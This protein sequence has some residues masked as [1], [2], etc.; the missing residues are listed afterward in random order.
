MELEL[1]ELPLVS[2]LVLFKKWRAKEIDIMPNIKFFL[3][4][5]CITLMKPEYSCLRQIISE[6]PCNISQAQLHS[7]Y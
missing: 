6:S 3:L 2:S 5:L 4:I 1:T 7:V